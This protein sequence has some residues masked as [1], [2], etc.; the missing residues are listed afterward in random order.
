MLRPTVAALL[1]ATAHA[2]PS[3]SSSSTY[4]PSAPS[5]PSSAPAS[6]VATASNTR[7]VFADGTDGTGSWAAHG[8][9]LKAY[10][11]PR[12]CPVGGFVAFQWTGLHDVVKMKSKAHMESCNF[13][14]ATQLAGVGNGGNQSFYYECTTPGEKA[15]MACSVGDHC[16]RGQKLEVRTSNDPWGRVKNADGSVKLHAQSLKD[17][18]RLLNA[19]AMDAGFQTESQAE[20]TLEVIWCLESHCPGSAEDWD[21]EATKASCQADVHNLAGYV[22]RKRP[23]PKLSL[24]RSYYEEALAYH[25]THC[26]ALQYLTELNLQTSNT[27][28][29]EATARALCTKCGASFAAQ[30]RAAFA[31]KG[32][33]ELAAC[34]DLSMGVLAGAVAGGVA[35]LL[36]VLYCYCKRTGG[37]KGLSKGDAAKPPKKNPDSYTDIGTTPSASSAVDTAVHAPG[38][39]PC[40]HVHEVPSSSSPARGAA[41][42]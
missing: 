31:A 10:E 28:G 42:A 14:G 3:E 9:V 6:P 17:V 27:S 2:A 15:F 36:L 30:T 32:L 12:G 4:E 37:L 33:P 41:N 20:H 21:A 25:P 24:A 38:A 5:S 34:A 13:E 18:M 26:P 1:V 29:A 39:M 16:K 19:P 22:S 23:K 11:K 35:V 7:F 8:S 40:V